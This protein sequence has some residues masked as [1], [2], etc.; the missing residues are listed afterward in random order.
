VD[1]RTTLAQFTLRWVIDQ[2][3]VSTVI[4]GARDAEQERGN[5]ASAALAPLREEQLAGVREV[6]DRLIR[7]HVHGRW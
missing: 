4:P 6:Y 1:P 2:P 7:P 5:A 3:G